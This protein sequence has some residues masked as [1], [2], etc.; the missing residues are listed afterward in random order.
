MPFDM[1]KI[2][3]GVS[4]LTHQIYL[5]RMGKDPKFCLYKRD[6]E[7]EVFATVIEYM[8]GKDMNTIGAK[9]GQTM[10]YGDKSFRVIVERISNEEFEHDTQKDTQ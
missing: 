5:Y 2:K 6:A 9:V 10:R 7:S 3:I 1:N 4:G 8:L